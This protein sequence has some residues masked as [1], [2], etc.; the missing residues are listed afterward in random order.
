PA[1]PARQPA[2]AAPPV[3]VRPAANAAVPPARPQLDDGRPDLAA[4]DIDDAVDRNGWPFERGELP[5]DGHDADHAPAATVSEMAPEDERPR[6][7]PAVDNEM[8]RLLGE[9]AGRS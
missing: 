8:A 1:A 4:N 5:G 7:G 6:S 3:P 9:I 2:Q